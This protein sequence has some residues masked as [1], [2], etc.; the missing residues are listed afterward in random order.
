VALLLAIVAMVI[1]SV[2]LVM[3][4]VFAA[5]QLIRLGP[6]RDS[7]AYGFGADGLWTLGLVFAACAVSLLS[8]RHRR[9]VTCQFWC[10]IM[11]ASWACLLVP[12]VRVTAAGGL[13]RTA[14]TLTLLA[15]LAMVLALAAI[16][17][18]WLEH[19]ERRQVAWPGLSDFAR[20]TRPWPGLGLSAAVI[21]AAVVLLVCYHLAVPVAVGWGGFRLAAF[22][23]TGSAALAALACFSLVGRMWS[24]SLADA[25]MALASVSLC[26]LATAAVPA[27]P[28]N[29]AERYPLIFNAMIVGLAVATGGCTRLG[30]I[31]QQQ[32]EVG[33]ARMTA[34]RLIPHARRFAFLNAALALVVSVAMALWPRQRSIAT[35]DHIYIRVVAG[36]S[37]NL[38]L[39]L[40]MLWCSRQLRRPTFH[41]LT[42]LVLA[43]TVAFLIVRIVPFTAQ[44]G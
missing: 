36:F 19:R 27:E 38:F 43:S 13:E 21:A 7:E 40:V 14:C 8:T 15:A 23:A 2:I 3:R 4:T 37:A 33:R 24:V 10:A 11:L 1:Q 44:F 39:L 16:A 29:L 6:H 34:G 12:P 42:L 22:V 20:G 35:M 5:M 26:S 17:T 9:L 18:G 31:W 30:S 25:A 41:I 28:A 32:R